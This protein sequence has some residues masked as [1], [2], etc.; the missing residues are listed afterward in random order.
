MLPIMANP[1]SPPML[2]QPGGCLCGQI[3]YQV[4]HTPLRVSFCHCKFCQRARGAAYA[5]E[6]IFEKSHYALLQGYP[7]TYDHISKGSGQI[8]HVHFCANCGAGIAYSFARW[9]DL[10]GLHAGTFDDPNWFDYGPDTAKHIFLDDAR[11]D[12]LIPPSLPTFAQHSTTTDGTPI[13]PTIY[14]APHRIGR[15]R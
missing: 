1:N 2:P 7:K 15:K 6:P 4:T 10:I 3:R 8:L 11:H 13:P 9:P 12:T 5:I 14:D